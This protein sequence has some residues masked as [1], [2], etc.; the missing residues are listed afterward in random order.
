MLSSGQR[1]ATP[2]TTCS[3]ARS[4][5]SGGSSRLARLGAEP[6]HVVLPHRGA[7]SLMLSTPQ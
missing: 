7:P 1:R 3:A 4:S 5:N 6:A 2:S